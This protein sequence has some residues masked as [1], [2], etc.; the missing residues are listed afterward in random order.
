MPHEQ[1]I[2]AI[3]FYLSA[4]IFLFGLPF[5]LSFALG[6]KFNPHTLRFTKT[7]LIVLKTQPAGAS[8]YLN[9]RL[10][11]IKTPATITELLPARYA[12]RLELESH[13][14][15]FNDVEVK[16]GTVR[17]MEKII[18]FPLRPNI[19]H[20][21][22]EYMSSFWIDLDRGLIYYVNPQDNT[23][24]KSDLEGRY[25]QEIANF[26]DIHPPALQWKVSGDREKILYFNNHQIGVAYLGLAKK[27]SAENQPFIIN[28]AKAKIN[29][30]FW[31]SDSYHLVLVSEKGIEVLEARPRSE[32][33]SLASLNKKDSLCFYDLNNDIL[34]FMDTQRAADG[35]LYDNLY[36]LELNAKTF[37]FGELIGLKYDE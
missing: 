15:W 23:I 22:N 33:I 35:I 17:R 9:N 20:M 37:P 10:L 28:Y 1:R 30:V 13:Y 16:A 3:L 12:I 27:A 7:G 36:R 4:I 18:L 14:P 11:N 24:Y 31:H 29:D 34:Y 32:F 19:K 8:I 25:S 2:R 5:I 21:N 6:Y 26:V